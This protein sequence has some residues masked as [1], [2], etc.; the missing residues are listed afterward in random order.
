LEKPEK[1]PPLNI[2]LPTSTENSHKSRNHRSTWKTWH[3]SKEVCRSL[4]VESKEI[5]RFVRQLKKLLFPPDFKLPIYYLKHSHKN[6]S[7]T[8]SSKKKP[9]KAGRLRQRFKE[10]HRDLGIMKKI[11][12][13]PILLHSDEL[14]MAELQPTEIDL[15]K[16]LGIEPSNKVIKGHHP[17]Q[18]PSLPTSEKRSKWDTTKVKTEEPKSEENSSRIK[19]N[20]DSEIPANSSARAKTYTA[21]AEDNHPISTTFNSRGNYSTMLENKLNETNNET[22]LFLQAEDKGSNNLDFF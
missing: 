5:I 10:I 20:T 7:S 4:I 2:Q 1:P 15:L 22:K 12:S 9:S 16:T 21:I 11:K 3:I 14:N 8:K 13:N 18:S 17:P 19:P 6:S